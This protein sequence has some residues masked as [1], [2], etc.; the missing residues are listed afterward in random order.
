MKNDKTEKRI[1]EALQKQEPH[2][3]RQIE[4]GGG[5]YYK[6]YWLSCGCDLAR[7]MDY[8]PKCGCKVDWRGVI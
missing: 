8:C 7:W 4:L 3:P 2:I 5:F 1:V 6:C